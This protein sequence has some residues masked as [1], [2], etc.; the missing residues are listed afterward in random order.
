MKTY[1]N[2]L[3]RQIDSHL[4][5]VNLPQKLEGFHDFISSWLYRDE[6][7]SFLVDP[8]P[9]AS[10]GVLE[11][12]LR[13]IGVNHLDY[14]LLTHIHI[15]H[16]GG[17]GRIAARFPEA[18]VICHPTGIKHLVDP[19]RLWK[20][21]LAVLGDIAKAY[22]EIGSVPQASI[23][24]EE[25][26]PAG[27]DA[28]EAIES[29]GHAPHH[30][31][32]L[33]KQYLFAGEVAGAHQPMEDRTYFRPATPPKFILETS[34]AS[35]EK[36]L[37]K[38]PKLLCNGHFGIRQDACTFLSLAGEQL[39]LWTDQVEEALESDGEDN[40]TARV[41]ERLME[42]DRIFSNF[43]YLDNSIKKRERYFVGNS[44]RGMKE[45]IEERS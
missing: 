15:D 38:K 41:M 39:A 35:L 31:S 24:F 16:A 36:V 18:H 14:V 4:F 29:P 19:A 33:F 7:V 17:A 22:G 12:A 32:Y 26:V 9:A 34:L 40:L 8:G 37:A 10:V 5:L 1:N 21:S 27:S 2:T 30:V 6:N 20:G 45:Y 28:I 23:S 25:R 11:E 42:K 43:E 44:I 3:Y 13:A